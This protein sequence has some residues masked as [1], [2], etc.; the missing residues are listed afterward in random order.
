MQILLEDTTHC[1][2]LGILISYLNFQ[3]CLFS[4][5]LLTN[6]YLNINGEALIGN[7]LESLAQVQG[8][9]IKSN[10]TLSPKTIDILNGNLNSS[11]ILSGSFY[12][13]QDYITSLMSNIQWTRSIS[14]DLSLKLN[15]KL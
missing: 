1:L 2:N 7:Y 10:F 3:K 5:K 14:K 15:S 9:A 11:V 4:S 8:T 6:P 13:P 12:P